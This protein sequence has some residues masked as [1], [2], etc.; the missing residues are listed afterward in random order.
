VLERLGHQR[1]RKVHPLVC[2][3]AITRRIKTE[4]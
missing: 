2:L 1:V 4:P 3:Q